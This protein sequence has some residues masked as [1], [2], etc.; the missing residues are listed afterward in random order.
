MTLLYLVSPPK[1]EL[2][3][4]ANQLRDALSA[5]KVGS[6]QLRLKDAPE[7]TIIEAV[8][9][10]LPIC[11]EKKVAFI[12]NDRPDLAAQFDCDGV[13]L[14][15]EDL[16]DISIEKARKIIGSD[17]ILGITCH[18]STGLAMDAGE[19]G[20]DYVAFG[21][22]Y[23]TTSKPKE[24]LDKWGT[25]K[26]EILEW[27]ST[28]TTLPCVAIGGITPANAAPLIKAGADFIAVITAVWNHPIGA[29]QAVKE[30]NEVLNAY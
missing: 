28:Y 6:F 21:A 22:F 30:F 7:S 3:A 2:A 26:P 29:K 18:D 9:V 20:A 25:P 10:L 27:W 14:G 13:H 1:I 4:F 12:L 15:Q 16:K 23:A 24:K 17:R 11:R 19:Q 5:G 8:K